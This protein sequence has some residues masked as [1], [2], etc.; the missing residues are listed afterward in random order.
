ML[1]HVFATCADAPQGSKSLCAI[2]AWDE[3]QVSKQI[4][5]PLAT[6]LIVA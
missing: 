5:L 6:Y 2:T 4:V 3:M 1:L